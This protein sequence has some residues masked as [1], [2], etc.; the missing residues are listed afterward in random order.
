MMNLTLSD[1]VDVFSKSGRPK[2]TKVRQIKHREEYQPATDYYRTLRNAL[3]AI[4]SSGKDRTA[5]DSILSAVTDPKKI[6]NYHELI[7]AYR[8][9]W[10]RKNIGWFNPPRGI[11]SYSGVD[12]I[13]NPELGLII[14]GQAVVIKLYVKSE[15]IS[16][17]QIELIPVLMEV[18]LRSQAA[19]GVLMALLDVRKG[20]LHYLGMSSIATATAM[21]NAELSYVATLWPD[22]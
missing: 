15:D 5:L 7:E 17:P 6:S 10:G 4:H 9:F 11:Y 13:V 16:R 3:V 1:V 19:D 8:K 14:D 12:V 22:L 2:A 18:V 20:K 21:I